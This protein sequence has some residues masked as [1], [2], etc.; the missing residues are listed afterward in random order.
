MD[1]AHGLDEQAPDKA[2]QP[3]PD[4]LLRHLIEYAEYDLALLFTRGQYVL[5]SRVGNQLRTKG[6]SVEALRA[7]FVE[8]PVD[9]GWLP[10]GVVRW[11]SGPGGTFLVTFI[12]PGQHT[13]HF[14]TQNVGKTRNVTVAL[15]GL[16]YA[17]VNGAGEEAS[18]TYYVW[19]IQEAKFDPAARLYHAPFPNVSTGDGRI[20]FGSNT[21]PPVSWKTIEAA[22]QLFVDAPFNADMAAFKSRQHPQDVRRQL[23]S[24]E[25]AERYPVSDLRPFEGGAISMH[26]TP[27]VQTVS[28]AINFYFLK[29]R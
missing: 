19:A 3:R 18:G 15:P 28:D 13:L 1:H 29:E 12:P 6:V 4:A 5:Y 11:G 25:G 22:W 21:A 9:S 24:L 14:T 10:P 20:C 23:L 16:I 27:P 7:A 8:E 26:S 2:V 17:G